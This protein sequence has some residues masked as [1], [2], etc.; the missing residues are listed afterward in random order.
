[1]EKYRIVK[2]R[3]SVEERELKDEFKTYKRE[4]NPVTKQYEWNSKGWLS[5]H[6]I[7]DYLRNGDEVLTAEVQ[8]KKMV[9]GAPA[10]LELRIATNE[11]K[12]KISEMPN[13]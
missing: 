12:F 7:S 9:D 1:M 8:E 3:S 13:K 10:E 2:A 6:E 4:L 5:I 11:T